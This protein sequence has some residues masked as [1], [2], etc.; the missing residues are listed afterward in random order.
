MI[1]PIIERQ[2]CLR[3]A[4]FMSGSGSNAE[5]LLASAAAAASPPWQAAVLV[6]D[7]PA[8]S[9]AA[10][11]AGLY[12]LPLIEHDIRAFYLARG[13]NGIS[14]KTPRGRL[15][16]EEWTAELRRLLTPFRIDF[17]L[18]AGFVPLTNIIAD[19]PCL[20]VHPGDLTIEKEGKRLLV[21]L[22]TIPI[23]RAIL[24]GQDE[25][26]ASVIV[27]QVYTGMGAEMDSGPILGLSPRVAIDRRGHTRA[28]LREI[29]RRRPERRPPG[30]YQDLLE[31]LA[32]FNQQQ[33]KEQG[34]WVVFPRATADFAAGRF[35]TDEQQ[36]LYYRENLSWRRIKTVIYTS[37]GKELVL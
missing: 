10:S 9:R 21:G 8:G 34:D 20:N 13:E 4:L 30:G 3:A 29:H 15:I 5:K 2:K 12:H 19:F 22:H 18:F 6:T 31:E 35:G 26:R 36:N 16:R 27:A 1:K 37:A 25:M 28:E 23:E 32:G 14:L 33:L 24:A 11:I 7:A 17:G